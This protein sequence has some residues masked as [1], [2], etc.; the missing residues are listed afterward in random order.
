[1]FVIVGYFLFSQYFVQ[2]LLS[3]ETI[4]VLALIKQSFPIN[5]QSSELMQFHRDTATKACYPLQCIKIN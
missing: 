3:L 4:T 1:M 5:M 2:V